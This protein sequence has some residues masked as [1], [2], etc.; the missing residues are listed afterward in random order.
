MP[1][2]LTE[3]EWSVIKKLLLSKHI[4]FGIGAELEKD[5]TEEEDEI[6][7]GVIN[8]FKGPPPKPHALRK[9][10][11]RVQR[12]VEETATLEVEAVSPSHAAS[13]ASRLMKDRPEAITSW[14]AGD[15][16]LDEGN[17]GYGGVYAV[18]DKDGD[19]VWER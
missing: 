14:E 10:K 4:E 3:P 5:L 16:I 17:M 19:T 12:Y 9:F 15:D 7:W 1:V 6:L 13:I 2:E 8:K 11:V 18:L